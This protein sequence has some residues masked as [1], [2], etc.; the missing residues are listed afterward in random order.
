MA[1]ALAG[2]G[3]AVTVIGRSEAALRDAVA[4]GEAAWY[5][6]ADVTDAAALSRQVKAAEDAR[7]PIAILVNNAGSVESGPFTKSRC[8]RSSAPCGTFI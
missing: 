4:A 5:G 6:I 7:G 1:A 8:R 3:A 2:A